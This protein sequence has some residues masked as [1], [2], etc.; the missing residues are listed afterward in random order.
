MRTNSRRSGWLGSV[1]VTALTPSPVL[2][3]YSPSRLPSVTSTRGPLAPSLYLRHSIVMPVDCP[4][5]SSLISFTADASLVRGRAK[6]HYDPQHGLDY[7]ASD[8]ESDPTE[9]LSTLERFRQAFRPT[10][11]RMEMLM[12]FC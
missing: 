3:V 10:H 12:Y 2:T 11:E 6:H 9:P 8:N 5:V 7:F 1:L 4:R